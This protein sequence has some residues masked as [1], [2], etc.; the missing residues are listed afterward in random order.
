MVYIDVEVEAEAKAM[1]M[2]DELKVDEELREFLINQRGHSLF[3]LVSFLFS[4]DSYLGFLYPCLL[5]SH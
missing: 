2:D 4:L 5:S 3:S 1:A